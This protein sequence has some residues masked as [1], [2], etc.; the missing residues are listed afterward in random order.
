M[1]IPG[2]YNLPDR[3][4]QLDR[5]LSDKTLKW[6]LENTQK[7]QLG[8]TTAYGP[9]LLAPLL[10]VLREVV[11]APEELK[12]VEQ[13]AQWQGDYPLE[14]TSATLFN[15]FL[16][17][18]ARA[19]FHEKLGDAYFD[20]LIQ[21]RVVDAALPR[22][23]ADP[24]SPWWDDRTTAQRESRAD[25]VK[26]AWRAS[27]DHLKRTLGPNPTQWRWGSAHTLTHGHPLGMQK[28][29]SLI[30]ISEPTRPY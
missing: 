19:T 22:L 29:L 12:L 4:Q 24:D 18:L 16:F 9:R 1:E 20:A 17:E 23:A 15:Q 11:V 7:L 5:Q 3:G 25:T 10:P 13:L 28:P 27:I 30:H 2:Y 8:T 14:S 6:D 26:Q 21:A